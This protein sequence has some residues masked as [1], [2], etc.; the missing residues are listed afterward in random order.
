MLVY[1]KMREM[2]LDHSDMW[3]PGSEGHVF[4]GDQGKLID[5]HEPRGRWIPLGVSRIAAHIL[6]GGTTFTTALINEKLEYL[7]ETIHFLC[8]FRCQL[9][10]SDWGWLAAPILGSHLYR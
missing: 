5:V 4:Q 2:R 8:C 7:Q 3:L 1:V 6:E 9:G 10:F